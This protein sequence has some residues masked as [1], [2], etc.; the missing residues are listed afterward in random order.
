MR[1]EEIIFTA[2]MPVT[3]FVRSV[4]LYPYHW[5]NT[6][7]I[8]YIIKGAAGFVMGNDSLLL[9]EKDIA[10]INTNEIHRITPADRD[11]IILFLYI[12]GDFVRKALPHHKYW[13]FYCCSAYHKENCEKY[14]KVKKF[15]L[16]LAWTYYKNPED[17]SREN[18]K[19]FIKSLAVNFDFLRWGY[20]N[21]PFGNRVVSR[22]H[23]IADHTQSEGEVKAGLGRLASDMNISLQHLSFDIKQKFGLTFQDLLQYSK[24]EQAVK[25]LISTRKH[26]VD[27]ALENGFS[28]VKYLIKHFKRFFGCTPSE[29]RKQFYASP[30]D[31]EKQ[32]VFKDIS[33]ND[34]RDL[35]L[36]KSL[37]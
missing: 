29:F 15:I 25:T 30:D 7:E 24:C 9:S 4:S 5:H 20:G 26:I 2:D 32:A 12:S 14:E 13:F 33:L 23:L 8:V 16:K 36:E 18:L 11:N 35:I 6:L 22:L 3:A 28:D 27:I 34:V 21:T 19:G 1:P 31:L 17:I 10:V 37:A